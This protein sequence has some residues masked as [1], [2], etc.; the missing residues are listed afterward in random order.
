MQLS[1]QNKIEVTACR[2]NDLNQK[3]EIETHPEKKISRN[4]FFVSFL[5]VKLF[6]GLHT[7][8]FGLRFVMYVKLQLIRQKTIHLKL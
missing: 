7:F 6:L 2:F 3:K 4:D 1:N 8:L 5:S